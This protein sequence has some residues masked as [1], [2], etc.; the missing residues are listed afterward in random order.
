VK[1]SQE[2]VSKLTE[3]LRWSLFALDELLQHSS[4]EKAVEQARKVSAQKRLKFASTRLLNDEQK[5]ELERLVNES[6]SAS[7]VLAN[8]YEG[9]EEGV[10]ERADETYVN[11]RD[12]IDKYVKSV[13]ADTTPSR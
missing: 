13:F 9:T 11:S 8:A 12:A 4:D 3:D 6:V 7:R 5:A 10:I 2:E 1:D